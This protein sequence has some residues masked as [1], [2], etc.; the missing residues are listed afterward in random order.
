MQDR[1]RSPRLAEGFNH[2]GRPVF[3]SAHVIGGDLADDLHPGLVARDID[4]EHRDSGRVRFL[5]H[6]ND[7]LRIARAE[8]DR[9]D[10]L[11]DEILDLV[12]LLGHV[13]VA[14]H[15]D[16]VVIIRLAGRGDVVSD[17]LEKRIIQRQQRDADDSVRLHGGLAGSGR[18]VGVV[19]A[20]RGEEQQGEGADRGSA[21]PIQETR[22]SIRP[23]G[24]NE[25]DILREEVG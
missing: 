1:D 10:P 3:S 25:H 7:R 8:D 24:M 14:A 12:P 19:A 13:L 5:D 22:L 6:R 17:H 15:D 16:H 23:R 4:G 2:R 9:A 21:R 20:D 11:D 18:H